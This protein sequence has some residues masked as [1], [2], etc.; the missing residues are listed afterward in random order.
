VKT[1]ANSKI[2]ESFE[3]NS[4]FRAA[5]EHSF[6]VQ[7]CDSAERV[8]V[9]QLLQKYFVTLF[10]ISCATDFRNAIIDNAQHSC[11]CDAPCP[12]DTCLHSSTSAHL[13]QIYHSQMPTWTSPTVGPAN[14]CY[15]NSQFPLTFYEP[16][17]F[18]A[19]HYTS[20]LPITSASTWATQS[21]SKRRQH[22]PPICHNKPLPNNL[23]PQK[24]ADRRLP[25]F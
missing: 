17:P 11:S 20:L 16:H 10:V 8:S 5:L 12:L 3:K 18:F 22:V 2:R 9:P 21:P 7:Q 19:F 1:G 13:N 24:T 4:C 15:R 14:S 23:K 6:T 25:S